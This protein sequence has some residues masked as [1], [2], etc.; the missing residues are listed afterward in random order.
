MPEGGETNDVRDIIQLA[1]AAMVDTYAGALFH[2]AK[3][4][5]AGSS[6]SSWTPD[7][8]TSAPTV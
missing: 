7:Q 3:E 6:N 2:R 4:I 8:A 5:A 1:W